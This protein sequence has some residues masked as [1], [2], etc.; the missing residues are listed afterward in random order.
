M[1]GPYLWIRN[2]SPRD[3]QFRTFFRASNG[4]GEGTGGRPTRSL[5]VMSM[6]TIRD[7]GTGSDGAVRP[8]YLAE[9]VPVSDRPGPWP[10]VVVI[11]DAFGLGDDIREQA[12]WLAAAGYVAL[13]P[14]LYNGRSMVRCIR[15]TTAA[16][17]AQHGP[18]FT[19]IEAARTHLTGLPA[20][21]GTVGVI[22]YCFGGAFA[23]LLAARPGYAAA[24]VNYGQLPRN[25]DEVL[26]GSCPMVA[27]YGGKDTTLK[28]AAAKVKRGLDLAG[29]ESDVREYPNGRHGFINRLAVASPLTVLL[30]VGGVGYDHDS[31]ADAK[32]RILEFFDHHLRVGQPRLSKTVP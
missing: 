11:H 22:G 2:P 13:V 15:S 9:P 12:D 25:L 30:K 4:S 24:A 6:I 32:R 10:G 3:K 8:A 1:P 28:G 27:S 20:C 23:L 14:D 19:Q 5:A 18:V 29:V 31:A 17:M 7:T 26:A 16:L 21:T